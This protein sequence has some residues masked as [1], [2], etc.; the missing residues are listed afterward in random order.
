MRRPLPLFL[1]GL[2][3]LLAACAEGAADEPAAG[4]AAIWTLDEDLRIDEAEDYYL[5]SVGGVAV[6]ADGALLVADPEAHHVKVISP[7]GKLI[8]TIGREGEGPG[9]FQRPHQVDLA[10]GDSL[11]VMDAQRR[12]SV[13]APGSYDFVRSL[14][15]ETEGPQHPME[16]MVLPEEGVLIT[17]M[18]LNPS[19]MGLYRVGED[20]SQQG[21]V[22][23]PQQARE[24]IQVEGDG[25]VMVAVKPFGRRTIAVLGPEERIYHGITDSLAITVSDFTGH[26]LDHWSLP[27]EP[28]SVTNDDLRAVE[29]DRS[30]EVVE[31]IR[32]A[33]LPDTQPAFHDLLVDDRRRVWIRRD[34]GHAETA[35]WWVAS[36]DGELLAELELPGHVQLEAV[37]EGYAY[38]FIRGGDELPTAI[39]Y[40]IEAVSNGQ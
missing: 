11:Y 37:R 2:L 24:Q 19:D 39:R 20:G 21:P 30:K 34:A 18:S 35:T 40:R 31:A 23:I 8:Q 6:R 14:T 4:E 25:G 29:E 7:E 27:A 17:Y 38:G 5:G 3:L 28:R 16:M 15:V 36:A 32:E 22:N 13:F 9:E 10:R 33:D 26:T 12:L 1:I